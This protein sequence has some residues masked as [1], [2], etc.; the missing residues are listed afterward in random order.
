MTLPVS[1]YS[2]RKVARAEAARAFVEGQAVAAQRRALRAEHRAS[3]ARADWQNL[4]TMVAQ[5]GRPVDAAMVRKMAR[6]AKVPA[7][8]LAKVLAGPGVSE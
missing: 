8:E 5:G 2:L 1:T 4:C 6:A 7:A 3:E